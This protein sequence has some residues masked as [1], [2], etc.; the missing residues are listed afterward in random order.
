[1]IAADSASFMAEDE[2]C[3]QSRRFASSSSDSTSSFSK[4][5]LFSSSRAASA[6]ALRRSTEL[7]GLPDE[8][9]LG[10]TGVI[11]LRTTRKSSSPT[12]TSTIKFD[13]DAFFGNETI[14][15]SFRKAS[16]SD[17]RH[18]TAALLSAKSFSKRSKSSVSA[19][20]LSLRILPSSDRTSSA[21]AF[22]CFPRS[23]A[24]RGLHEP[25]TK[26]SATKSSPTATSTVCAFA[27]AFVRS[28]CRA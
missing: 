5:I 28:V 23:A 21:I 12:A 8:D 7:S 13:D 15:N 26:S 4:R 2:D 1:M 19:S 18:S 24:I 16:S 27:R 6:L 9:D 20:S 14:A 17:R 25:A 11:G 10:F 3:S 22:C